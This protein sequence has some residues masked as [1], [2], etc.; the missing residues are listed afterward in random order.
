MQLR[1]FPIDIADMAYKWI[2]ACM[3]CFILFFCSFGAEKKGGYFHA[4]SDEAYET[5]LLLVQGNFKVSVAERTREQRNAV[6]RYRR[7]RDSLHLGPQ[8][9]PTLYFDGKKVVKKS[10]IGVLLQQHLIKQ[11]VV[12]VKNYA[13][14]PQLASQV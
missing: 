4:L 3:G 10:S 5:L 1:S 8:S 9:A 6:V 12:D 11:K 2:L 13:I 7:Q 14:E